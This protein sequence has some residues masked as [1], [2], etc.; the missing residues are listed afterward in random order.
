M[1]PTHQLL[2]ANPSGPQWRYY[3]TC[4]AHF[5]SPVAEEAAEAFRC[6]MVEPAYP[7]ETKP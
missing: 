5:T 1:T 7:Q 6:H 3:C 4:G 2:F